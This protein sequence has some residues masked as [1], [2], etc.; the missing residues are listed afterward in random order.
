MRA[1]PR[2]FASDA[3]ALSY[4]Q[5]LSTRC[6]LTARWTAA[7]EN[8]VFRCQ[9][10]SKGRTRKGKCRSAALLCDKAEAMI[11]IIGRWRLGGFQQQ[12]L[13]QRHQERGSFCG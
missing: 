8:R 10:R 12:P 9:L 11:A 4:R 3:A 1:P 5:Y 6:S 13:S 2:R 7:S